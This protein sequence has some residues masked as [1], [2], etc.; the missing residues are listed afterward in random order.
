MVE[1]ILLID[2]ATTACRVGLMSEKELLAEK[3]TIGT[4]AHAE[5]LSVLIDTLMREQNLLF[6]E[7]TALAIT[8]G[9][10]SYTGLRIGASVAKGICYGASLKLISINTLALMAQ[11]YLLKHECLSENALLVPMIDARRMEVFTLVQDVKQQVLLQPQAM[12]L[13]ESSFEQFDGAE[14]HFFGDGAEKYKTLFP[15]QARFSSDMYLSCAAMI[16]L[17]KKR[18]LLGQFESVAYYSPDYHKDF[19][20][21]QSK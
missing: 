9:P 18:I 5:Q 3:S 6:S 4:Y 2:T 13:E 7:L 19:F 20:T 21:P 11:G 8:G 15:G 14:L 1:R 16:P 10:G 12:V 17:V